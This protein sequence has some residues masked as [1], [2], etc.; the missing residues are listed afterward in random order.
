MVM[1]IVLRSRASLSGI[2]MMNYLDLV[3][4][5]EEFGKVFL[6]FSRLV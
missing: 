1:T 4:F 6:R 2:G 5:L 3:L